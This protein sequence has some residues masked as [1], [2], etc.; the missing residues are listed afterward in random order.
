MINLHTVNYL[1]FQ[2]KQNYYSC[3]V[4]L[5]LAIKVHLWL[6]LFKMMHSVMIVVMVVVMSPFLQIRDGWWSFNFLYFLK[7]IFIYGKQIAEIAFCKCM[8]MLCRSWDFVK[9]RN[10]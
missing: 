10:L 7:V 9:G 8:S 1:T 6:H 3:N 4:K 5:Y 2:L